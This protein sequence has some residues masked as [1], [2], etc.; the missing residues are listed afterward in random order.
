MV[1]FIEDQQ[2]NLAH[3]YESIEQSVVEDFSCTDNDHV[4]VQQ[5]LPGLRVPE[6]WT[7]GAKYVCHILIK[8]ISENSRLLED[9]S[10]TIYLLLVSGVCFEN[11]KGSYQEECHARSFFII[12]VDKL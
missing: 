3:L 12:T 10:H 8:V 5:V 6:I 1:G 7:H 11:I 4:S 9:K 2:I